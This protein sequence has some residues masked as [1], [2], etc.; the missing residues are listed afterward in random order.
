LLVSQQAGLKTTTFSQ[1]YPS[2]LLKIKNNGLLF[3]IAYDWF[4]SP[5]WCRER[6]YDAVA[7]CKV[8]PGLCGIHLKVPRPWIC[9]AQW[10]YKKIK[11][12]HRPHAVQRSTSSSHSPT[13]DQ[14]GRPRGLPLGLQKK[15]K[16]QGALGSQGKKNRESSTGSAVGNSGCRCSVGGPC[17]V[18]SNTRRGWANVPRWGQRQRRW[19]AA[20]PPQL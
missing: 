7:R 12:A 9:S 5:N 13:A 15:N 3:L 4:V 16:D 8:V 10:A 14:R 11:T 2:G 20:L 17:L 1:T 18:L 19:L 6:Q